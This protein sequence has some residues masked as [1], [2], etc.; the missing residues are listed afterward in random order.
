[1]VLCSA[2]SPGTGAVG[3]EESEESANEKAF[4]NF[5]T[6]NT[7]HKSS[8]SKI[9]EAKSNGSTNEDCYDRCPESGRID[10]PFNP[11]SLWFYLELFELHIC[12][13]VYINICKY[14]TFE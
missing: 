12:R 11:A 6:R 8:F 1:M 9:K 4:N 13:Y 7:I 2:S 10:G 3:Y 5:I 14:N